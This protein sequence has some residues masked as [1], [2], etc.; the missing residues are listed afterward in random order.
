MNLSIES[1]NLRFVLSI[2]SIQDFLIF[3]L[4]Q[5]DQTVGGYQLSDIRYQSFLAFCCQQC[6]APD[7]Q[8]FPFFRFLFDGP[9]EPKLGPETKQGNPLNHNK[10]WHD[11]NWISG[12]DY[13]ESGNLTGNQDLETWIEVRQAREYWVTSDHSEHSANWQH[14]GWCQ[15]MCEKIKWLWLN[16]LNFWSCCPVIA[17][18]SLSAGPA[19][20]GWLLPKC[21]QTGSRRPPME[22]FRNKREAK[23]A[24]L[25]LPVP[26]GRV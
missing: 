2:D 22:P 3:Y 15:I 17:K 18:L 24:V 23:L 7:W 26:A 20:A 14:G 5:S 1:M 11:I 21:L 19:S 4:Y 25:K 12:N 13:L 9:A 16:W 10:T 6:S 8:L